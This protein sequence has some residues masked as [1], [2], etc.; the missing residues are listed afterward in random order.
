MVG[1]SEAAVY[2]RT[3]SQA[4]A[5]EMKESYRRQLDAIKRYCQNSGVKF[6][7]KNVYYDKGVSGTVP[8][9][10]RPAFKQMLSQMDERGCSTI[11]IEDVSRLARDLM[12]QEVTV[13]MCKNLN[14][15]IVPVNAPEM[16]AGNDIV[17][18]LVRHVIGAV[19]EFQRAEVVER[20]RSARESKLKSTSYRT[21]NGKPKVTG[22]KS[23]LEGKDG[24]L[25]K[26]T[27]SRWSSKRKLEKGDLSNA[28]QALTNKGIRTEA[29]EEVS[30][31][32]VQT[33]IQAG[34]V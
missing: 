15:A 25:I 9:L 8:I 11:L 17:K 30:L 16:L 13:S 27:L 28:Q 20:L 14:F 6:N 12:V 4:N 19:T 26:T 31:S 32:Q 23:R 18:T 3:S 22:K 29:G 24:K 7:S 10:E 5:G 1:R 33:W 2:I 34:H 21:L